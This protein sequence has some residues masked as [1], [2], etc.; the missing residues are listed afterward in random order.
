MFYRKKTRNVLVTVLIVGFCAILFA[1]NG[2]SASAAEVKGEQASLLNLSDDERLYLQYKKVVKMCIDPDWMPYE[3][4]SEQGTH[5]GM[6]ADYMALFEQRIGIPIRLVPTSSWSDTLQFGREKRCDILSLLNESPERS[7]FLNFTLPYVEAPI[8]LVTRDDVT[9][10]EGISSLGDRTI[11]TPK[12]YIYE[13]RIKND[14]PEIN[15]VAVPTVTDGLKRVSKGEI[16]THLGSLY[17]V[18]NQIQQHQLSNLK[19]SGHTEYVHNLAVGVRKDDLILLAILDKAVRSITQE[20]HIKIRQKWTVTNI[21]L[22]VDTSLLWKTVL[23]GLVLLA[24]ILLWNRKLV[25]LNAR[26]ANILEGTNAGTWDWDVV[27]GRLTI[28]ERWAE[29]IG[30]TLKELEPVTIQ[31]W[32]D[33]LHSDDLKI[34]ETA[35]TR[36]FARELDYY[37]VVFRQL[38]K[39]GGW[40]WVNAR[41]KVV[42]RAKDGKPLRMSGTHLDI[43]ERKLAE[44][45]SLKAKEE[46]EK[47]NKA[48]SEFL[49]SMSHE[50]R[51]PLNAV[52]GFAQMLQFDPKNPLTLSQNE[53]IENILE[54]GEHLL[55]LINEILDLARIEADQLDLTLEE[56][57]ANDVVADCVALTS[58][59]GEARG[60][61][62]INQFSGRP[63]AI[64]RTDQLR[65][66][67]VLLNLLSN[68]VKYNRDGGTVTVEGHETENGFLYLSLTDT[69]IGIAEVDYSG[70]FQMFHRIGADP[71]V[72]REGTGIGL[73][74]TK[75]L[76]ERMAGR[77]GCESEQDVGSTFWIELPLASNEEVL[78]WTDSLR[79]GLDAIDKDHQVIVSLLNRVTHRFIEDAELDAMI[80]ELIDYTR[81]HF[82]REEAIMEICGYPD[83]EKHRGHH[84][85]LTAQVNDL[86]DTWRKEHN[87][88]TLHHLRK[89]LRE[90]WIDHIMK[91]DTEIAQHGK[92]KEQEI[93][94]ALENLG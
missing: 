67:Q 1:S 26:I 33:N 57:N 3:R 49:A 88:E 71:M 37:D 47:A 61:K 7:E 22:G 11:S 30:Y 36:H 77:I 81:H 40:V 55:E 28:N 6:S 92:G 64:L 85:D 84:W 10:L 51:T 4:I 70:V 69:G 5:E 72:A 17:V 29:I 43:T 54:G 34:A 31:T 32:S 23:G 21:E 8:V 78:I 56:V 38:H 45:Q 89:F 68:A 62:V 94:Q 74:V 59:L 91:V 15:L 27:T 35:L 86:A 90:W 60:I 16:F 25:R 20:E 52:L 19:V 24:A 93:R 79:V 13:E 87:P 82:R 41:G 53:H 80:G 83:L 73:T 42:E 63:S 9:F 2:R 75:L 58:P 14:Y 76:V 50:L 48:K 12:G 65:L 46:A 18:V 39:D 44:E 66:K